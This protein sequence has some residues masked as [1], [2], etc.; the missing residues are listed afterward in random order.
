MDNKRPER[1]EKYKKPLED[2][3]ARML[4]MKKCN[5]YPRSCCGIKSI[6]NRV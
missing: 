4:E 1:I 6:N 2:E 5:S 3:I